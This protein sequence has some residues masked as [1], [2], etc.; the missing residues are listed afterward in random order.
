[1]KTTRMFLYFVAAMAAGSFALTSCNNDDDDD[2]PPTLPPGA[3]VIQLTGDL[4]TQTLS[5]GNDYLL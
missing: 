3:S 2:G 4:T 1:M 5:P